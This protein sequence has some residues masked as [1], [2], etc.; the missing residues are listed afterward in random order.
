MVDIAGR[1]VRNVSRA[2]PEADLLWDGR[3]D[4]GE[5]VPPGLYFVRCESGARRV[6]RK[7]VKAE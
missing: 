5:P 1:R 2:A 7:V 6:Q 4:R 3:N